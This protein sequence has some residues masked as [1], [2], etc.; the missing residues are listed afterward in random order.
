M[1]VCFAAWVLMLTSFADSSNLRAGLRELTEVNAT[2]LETRLSK[3]EETLKASAIA[4]DGAFLLSNALVILTMQVSEREHRQTVTN[5]QI[6]LCYGLPFVL[7][8][9]QAGFA[10]LEAGAV[11]SSSAISM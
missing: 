7:Y 8:L 3:I 4:A 9:P 11:V 6:P 2:L 1:L 5:A 10:M